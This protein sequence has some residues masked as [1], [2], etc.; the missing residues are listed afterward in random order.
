MVTLDELANKHN[1]DKG[2]RYEHNTVHGYAPIY[3]NYLSKW[4]DKPIRLL[5]V[6]ICMEYTKGGQSVRMWHEYFQN[7]SIYTFDIVDMKHLEGELGDRVKFYKGDQSS[8]PDLETMY[9]EFGSKQFDFILEDGSHIHNHQMI[10]LAYLFKY[11][12]SGGYYILEDITE[13]GVHACCQRNDETIKIIKAL[14]NKDTVSCEFIFPE[15]L[16]YLNKNISKIEI[17]QDI[18]NA[19]RTAII[20][21]K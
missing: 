6:G 4:R 9:K 12:K 7:A 14:Q 20:H 11:V 15:E 3:E 10:S 13:E 21:K 5:E 16:D 17:H 2:T 8:R 1:T 18:Q 19:Y